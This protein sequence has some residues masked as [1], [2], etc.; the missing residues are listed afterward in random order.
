MM[1]R[2]P[3]FDDFDDLFS[4]LATQFEEMGRQFDMTRMGGGA[5]AVDLRDSG[6]RFEVT[7]DLPGYSTEEI[8]LSVSGQVLHI[9]A[10]RTM[11]ETEEAEGY[12]RQERQ[13]AAVERRVQLPEPVVADEAGASYN[14]GVLTV[15]L[16]KEAPRDDGAHHIDVE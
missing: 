13:Q 16:P 1:P 8:D 3:P 4:R 6:D 12:I 2:T 10:D 11:A 14:N 7:A 9:H 5:A 15:T